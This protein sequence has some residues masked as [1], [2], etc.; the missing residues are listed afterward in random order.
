MRLLV[1]GLGF[2]RMEAAMEKFPTE[3]GRL[4]AAQLLTVF[5][6][7]LTYLVCWSPLGIDGLHLPLVSDACNAI[8]TASDVMAWLRD[9]HILGMFVWTGVVTTAF[10]IYMETLAL[11][12]LSAT[13]TTLIFSTEPLFGAAFAAVVANECLG[14]DDA[15]GAAFIII[16]CVVSG[17]D[18]SRLFRGPV[19]ESE[20]TSTEK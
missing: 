12:T 15:V 14:M 4:A 1:F 19:A 3:A 17:M 20:T 10:T 6:V 8:P 18:V 9:P 7:S 2:W 16:G 13:E 5:L 11:R